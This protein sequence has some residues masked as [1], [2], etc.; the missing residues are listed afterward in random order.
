MTEDAPKNDGGKVRFDLLPPHALESLARVY[1]NGAGAEYPENS[2][3]KGFAY[4]RIF[5][6]AMRHLWAFWRG[7]NVD[8]KTG[9]HHLMQSAWNCF[10][11]FEM[12]R[13]GKGNDDRWKEPEVLTT[14]EMWRQDGG[15]VD[16]KNGDDGSSIMDTDQ[17]LSLVLRKA[18]HGHDCHPTQ[19]QPCTCWKKTFLNQYTA[20]HIQKQ[21]DT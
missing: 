10:T 7:E 4:T 13:T 12:E 9:M 20:Q 19:G 2:W 3:R 1:M 11:L 15:R 18:P 16:A 8:P 5:S 17:I 6:A 21:I 14:V